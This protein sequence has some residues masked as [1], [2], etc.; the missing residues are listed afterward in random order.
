M[1]IQEEQMKRLRAVVFGIALVIP[2]NAPV[3]ASSPGV[4]KDWVPGLQVSRAINGPVLASGRLYDKVGQP[5]AGR[6]L[7]IAWPTLATLHALHEG[8]AVK[9]IPI[10]QDTVGEDGRFILRVDPSIPL[11]EYIE[12]NGTINIDV[13]SAGADGQATFSASRRLAAGAQT[14]WIDPSEPDARPP[15]IEFTLGRAAG[16]RV[17]N[18][19]SV[20]VPAEAVPAEDKDLGCSNY[21]VATYDQDWTAIGETYPGPSATA[22]FKYKAD[23]K[24]RLGVG[25]SATGSYGSYSLSGAADSSSSTEI[26]WPT[27]PANS[28]WFYWTTFQYKKFDVWV[29]TEFGCTHFDYEVRPTAFQGGVSSGTVSSAPTANNCSPIGG[30]V[31]IHKTLGT[32]VTWTNGVKIS[33][34][35]GIDLSSRTGFDTQTSYDFNFTTAGRLCGSNTTYPQAAQVV[36]KAW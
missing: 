14:L 30:P 10:A 13:L 12:D 26:T 32:A 27:K 23:S 8:D 11:G 2:I 34:Y 21:V 4:A 31:L 5:A 17:G 3:M 15:E 25:V 19:V 24:S 7:A 16:R 36:G 29:P 33:S 28:M 18:N 22:Q 20:A 6:V 35:I 1:D 9:T